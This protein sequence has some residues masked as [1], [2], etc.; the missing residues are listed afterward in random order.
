MV[1]LNDSQVYWALFKCFSIVGSS[2][3]L[4]L[5]LAWMVVRRWPSK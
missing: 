1:A 4:L 2:L 5:A 3:L